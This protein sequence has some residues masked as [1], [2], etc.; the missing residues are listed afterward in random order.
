M[1]D[2]H[3]VGFTFTLD[4]A[5]RY[6]PLLS[7]PGRMSAQASVRPTHLGDLDHEQRADVWEY[8]REL[9]R[10]GFP[11]KLRWELVDEYAA[12]VRTR[13]ATPSI[14]RID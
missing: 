9:R 13:E 12:M 10:L 4:T 1:L 8:D 6:T 5:E 2:R 11:T 14:D 7:T 3:G